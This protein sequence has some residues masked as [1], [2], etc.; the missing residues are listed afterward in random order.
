MSAAG[1]QIPQESPPEAQVHIA[2]RDLTMAYGDFV[3]QRDLDFEI[4]RGDIFVIMGGSG[5]G[6]TTLL[7][8]MVG[9]KAP[10]SGDVYYGDVGYWAGSDAQRDEL[11]RRFGVMY[12]GGALWSSMTLLENVSL[13]LQEYTDLDTRTIEEIAALKLALV[14]LRGFENF[15][16]SEISGGMHKRAGLARA[17][18]PRPGDPL[19]R[20]ALGGPRPDQLQPARLADPGAA[21]QPGG[22]GGARHP[23]AALDPGHRHA[24]GLPGRPRPRP[25]SPA[26]R[27]GCSGTS[28]KT[29]ACGASCGGVSFEPHPAL[30]AK[31]RALSRIRRF[32]RRGEL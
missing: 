7:R 31:G 30:P 21:R 2:V 11:T 28:A 8:H 17:M 16:P 23:R 15:Y 14:G 19:L 27:P 9:L 4:H 25:S 10:V 18:G 5:C 6:K 13:T 12:Q 29:S 24:L 22:H 3:I 1:S 20:R 26:A 32:L